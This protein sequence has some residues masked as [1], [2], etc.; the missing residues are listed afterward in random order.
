MSDIVV[1]LAAS[2]VAGATPDA[3][4][5]SVASCHC[6]GG[7][8]VFPVA[9]CD[10]CWGEGGEHLTSQWITGAGEATGRSGESRSQHGL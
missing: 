2:V 7:V 4:V 10:H 8:T 5:S 1:H 3:A 6:G 9:R